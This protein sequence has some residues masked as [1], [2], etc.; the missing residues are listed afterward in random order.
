MSNSTTV[1]SLGP[2][3]LVKYLCR[4]YERDVAEWKSGSELQTMPPVLL[5]DP[6][7]G[8][9]V[10]VKDAARAICEKNGYRFIDYKKEFA[11]LSDGERNKIINECLASSSKPFFFVD[12]NMSSHEPVD[13]SGK[14]VDRVIRFTDENGK[15]VIDR[16]TEFQP[17]EWVS[18]LGRYPG[19]L[20]VDEITNVQREDMKTV[21]YKL[22][23]ERTLGYR[24]LGL[25]A[26]IVGAGNTPDVAGS[27]AQGM[28]APLANRCAF[29]T[30]KRPTAE[31]W[32]EY[33]ISKR[34][35]HPGVLGYLS[36]LAENSVKID[37]EDR[38]EGFATPRSCEAAAVVATKLINEHLEG[39][40]ASTSWFEKELKANVVARL[41]NKEGVAFCN[42]VKDFVNSA[43]FFIDKDKA[44]KVIQEGN[45]AKLF[46][47]ISIVGSSI[48]DTAEQVDNRMRHEYHRSVLENTGRICAAI[49]N[50]N[51]E[52]AIPLLARARIFPATVSTPEKIKGE[53]G[54]LYFLTQLMSGAN[55][56]DAKESLGA[57]DSWDNNDM[58]DAIS[59]KLPKIKNVE[60]PLFISDSDSNAIRQ[61]RETAFT[62]AVSNAFVLTLS[63]SVVNDRDAYNKI[64]ADARKK[65]V[66]DYLLK[67]GDAI[68]A[69]AAL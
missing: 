51:K 29:V 15:E 60:N 20:F 39:R 63:Q 14:P 2:T 53:F 24:E 35:F 40:V 48:P 1:V 61:V 50:K 30:V 45:T 42:F 18:Y 34:N 28:P 31:E 21:L 3:E 38:L 22:L 9:T 4:S 69:R 23:N 62:R 58:L 68:D 8:K 37:G 47:V 27:V 67:G 6:G 57:Y 10:A 55:P 11:R 56:V 54:K 25:E 16:V 41:G 65:E 33:E 59:K 32:Y 66:V 17:P 43:N 7:V 5:G 49:I 12:L 44:D 13:F 46:G 36:Y 52:F 64:V 26:F 19:I